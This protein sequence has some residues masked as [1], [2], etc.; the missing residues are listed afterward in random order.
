MLLQVFRVLAPNRQ[1]FAIKRVSM[2]NM[3]EQTRNTYRYEVELLQRLKGTGATVKLYHHCEYKKDEVLYVVLE[4]GECDLTQLLD[5]KTKQWKAEGHTDPFVAD[6]NF[7]CSL[8]HELLRVVKVRTDQTWLDHLHVLIN[9]V[10][11]LDMLCSKNMS[12]DATSVT[13]TQCRQLMQILHDKL[14]VHCDIKPAN[15]LL[16]KG[17]LKLIDFGI[18]RQCGSNTTA[19]DHTNHGTLNYMSPESVDQ[20]GKHLCTC[21]ILRACVV[22]V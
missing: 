14:I 6:P 18:A 11:D 21:L 10:Q 19:I 13:F 20:S 17:R 5:D 3:P 2:K 16:V 12:S 15:I 4:C 7:I 1:Q 22:D 9:V 8:W